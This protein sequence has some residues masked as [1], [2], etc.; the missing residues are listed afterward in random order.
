[1]T[2]LASPSLP[3]TRSRGAGHLVA[4]LVTFVLAVAGLYALWRVAIRTS[5]GQRVD[6]AAMH[7]ADVDH[8]RIVE[9]LDRTLNGTTGVSLVLV[10]LFA[11][12][13]GVLRRRADLAIGAAVL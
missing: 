4:P 2:A 11:A 5:V 7:G 12:A 3:D 13:F 10:C 9:I 1:M 6:T 8:S